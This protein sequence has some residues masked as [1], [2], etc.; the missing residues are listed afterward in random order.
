MAQEQLNDVL[1][2]SI[3]CNVNYKTFEKFYVKN[4]IIIYNAIYDSFYEVSKN[5]SYDKIKIKIITSIDKKEWSTDI[6]FNRTDHIILKRDLIPFYESIEDYEKCMD[7][8]KL[9]NDLL[10]TLDK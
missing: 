4:K 6:E 3:L 5:K 10:Y 1:E 7:I 9:Y 2:K 8:N